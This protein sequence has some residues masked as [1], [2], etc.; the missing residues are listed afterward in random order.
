MFVL[1]AKSKLQASPI[2]PKII[3]ISH[4][5]VH[6]LYEPQVQLCLSLDMTSL[7]QSD[8]VMN[9]LKK[10]LCELDSKEQQT[11]QF[12]FNFTRPFVNLKKFN[13]MGNERPYRNQDW[14]LIYPY[15]QKSS[16]ASVEKP[17]SLSNIS[18]MFPGAVVKVLIFDLLIGQKCFQT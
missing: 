12:I 15:F 16:G 4:Q 8:N 11:K 5:F 17:S 14:R 9:Q 18:N 7:Y 6:S 10:Q 3:D 1:D 13:E 2:Y